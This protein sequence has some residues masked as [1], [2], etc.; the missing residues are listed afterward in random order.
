MELQYLGCFNLL[1][2]DRK[3][4]LKHIA[5]SLM[6]YLVDFADIFLSGQEL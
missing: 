4:F 2:T 3:S 1:E 6:L 5:L